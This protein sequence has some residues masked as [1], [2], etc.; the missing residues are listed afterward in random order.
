MHSDGDVGGSIGGGGGGEGGGKGGGEGDGG[1]GR[2]CEG[3]TQSSIYATPVIHAD[4]FAKG[5]RVGSTT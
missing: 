1:D 3:V 4:S 2:G 5:Q